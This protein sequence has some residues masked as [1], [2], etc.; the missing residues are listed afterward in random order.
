MKNIRSAA[1]ALLYHLHAIRF[2]KKH[3]RLLQYFLYPALINTIVFSLLFMIS[4]YILS[5]WLDTLLAQQ[6]KGWL[7][8]LLYYLTM[9]LSIS[10][11]ALVAFFSFSTI[12]SLIAAPF[13]DLLSQ[14]V[15]EIYRGINLEQPFDWKNFWQDVTSTIFQQLQRLIFLALIWVIILPGLLIPIL[16]QV[17]MSVVTFTFLAFEYL[18]LPLSRRRIKFAEK[19]R[20]LQSHKLPMLAFGSVCGLLMAVPILNI[21]SIPLSVVGGALFYCERVQPQLCIESYLNT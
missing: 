13:N 7:T 19:R 11:L 3:P 14:R 4:L 12:G 16:G 10:F 6:A 20:I 1:Q 15:E 17:L 2:V 9:A 18:D 21:L 5:D 8:M